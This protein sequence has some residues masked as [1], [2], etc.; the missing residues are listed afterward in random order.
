MSSWRH[1]TQ[2]ALQFWLIVLEA[3]PHTPQSHSQYVAMRERIERFK[4]R[5]Q[6]TFKYLIERHADPV[7]LLLVL[8]T[9]CDEGRVKQAVGFPQVFTVEKR[10]TFPNDLGDFRLVT[11]SDMHTI[12]TARPALERAGL[13]HTL[14]E[15]EGLRERFDALPPPP[16]RDGYIG[17][18]ATLH[19]EFPH[20]VSAPPPKTGRPGEYYFNTAMVLLNRHLKEA[21]PEAARYTSIALLLN[22][23]CPASFQDSRLSKGSVRQRILSTRPHVESYSQFLEGWFVSWKASIQRDPVPFDPWAI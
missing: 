18:K 17:E 6:P 4:K 10:G 12:E 9:L 19:T 14:A 15:I 1:K 7:Y 20:P 2:R 16:K 23:F 13:T 21:A 22:A 3:G 8:I 11:E 5:S